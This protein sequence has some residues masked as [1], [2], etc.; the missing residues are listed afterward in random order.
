MPDVAHFADLVLENLK[1]T[2]GVEAA[3]QR[4]IQR[5][6][7]LYEIID[8]SNGFYENKVDPVYRSRMNIPLRIRT[9]TLSH[10][11][12]PSPA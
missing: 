6:S 8:K 2:G 12:L 4:A 5:S 11:G 1:A 9:Q 3:Q 7:T 10:P